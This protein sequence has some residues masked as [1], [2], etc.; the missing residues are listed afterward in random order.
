M[1]KYFNRKVVFDGFK[2][3]SKKEAERYA[4]LVLM[5]K[6]GLIKNLKLQPE[7]VLIDSFI[8]KKKKQRET[9]YIADFLY[10]DNQKRSYV[11][12]DVKSAYLARTNALYKLKR[13]MFFARYPLI[14]F[15]EVLV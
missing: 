6:G 8:Y 5:Q 12:E 2:F 11:V 10:F 13:K 9:K 14:E 4:Q 7:F 1:S 15:V 3:D